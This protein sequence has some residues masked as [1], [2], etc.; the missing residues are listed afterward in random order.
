MFC[1]K[2]IK[3]MYT[4]ED[5]MSMCTYITPNKICY[6]YT[7]HYLCYPPR[8]IKDWIEAINCSG[9]SAHWS[10]PPWKEKR[11]IRSL[12]RDHMLI[13]TPSGQCISCMYLHLYLCIWIC[14]QQLAVGVQYQILRISNMTFLCVMKFMMA[15]YT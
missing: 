10:S 8:N 4:W 2:M 6:F 7:I 12:S 11:I 13:N 15:T 5:I 1:R 14:P 3:S 9:S